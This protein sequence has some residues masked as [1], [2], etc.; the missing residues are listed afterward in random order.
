MRTRST[1]FA[2]MMF[3]G[4]IV[5]SSCTQPAPANRPAPAPRSN[6][7]MSSVRGISPIDID[8]SCGDGT[9]RFGMNE[10]K[11]RVF[12]GKDNGIQWRLNAPT[13]QVPGGFDIVPKYPDMW[14][15][16]GLTNGRDHG[17]VVITERHQIDDPLALPHKYNIE[18]V[19]KSADGKDHPV[20]ID[21]EVIIVDGPG[22]DGADMI[23]Q[24]LPGN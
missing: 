11:A 8:V 23:R 12:K 16:A 15:F 3:G 22:V 10:W 5:L 13:G 17:M 21:P 7:G 14:P 24:G 20:V 9:V 19:C 6:F 18:L 2:V 1:L 4:S